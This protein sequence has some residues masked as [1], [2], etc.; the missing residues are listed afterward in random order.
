MR[1]QLE[2]ED[3]KDYMLLVAAKYIRDNCPYESLKYDGV[4]CD[5]SCI[6]DECEGASDSEY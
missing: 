5:G 1:E 3:R 4:V 6:A 2:D